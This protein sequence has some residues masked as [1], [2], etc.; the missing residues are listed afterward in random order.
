M[1]SNQS[2]DLRKRMTSRGRTLTSRGLI[3]SL[4]RMMDVELSRYIM[5]RLV[6]L[7]GSMYARSHTSTFTQPMI[8]RMMIASSKNLYGDLDS[9]SSFILS[10]GSGTKLRVTQRTKTTHIRMRR[11]RIL[12]LLHPNHGSSDISQRLVLSHD[13]FPSM[14]TCTTEKTQSRLNFTIYKP[15]F[16]H[17][18]IKRFPQRL[19]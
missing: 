16:H 18:L 10:S 12:L 19:V 14:P 1:V 2:L 15:R 3:G 7:R 8:G 17:G 11:N 5:S 4:S 13:F 6:D 9:T